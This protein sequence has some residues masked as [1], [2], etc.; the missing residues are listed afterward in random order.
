MYKL[1]YIGQRFKL[2]RK[3]YSKQ[4]DLRRKKTTNLIYV[5]CRFE[6]VI[7]LIASEYY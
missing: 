6:L 7:R 3:K 4:L 5:K 2:N 1:S